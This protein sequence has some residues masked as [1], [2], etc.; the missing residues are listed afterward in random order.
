MGTRP[1]NTEAELL[2]KDR[3]ALENAENQSEIAA[4]LTE[5]GYDTTVIA[6]GKA[7]LAET[8]LAFD[9]NKTEDDETSEASATFKA[10]KK[11]LNDLFKVHR[12]KAKVI[13]RNDELTLK[14]LAINNS[15][16]NAYV[17]WLEEVK[18]FYTEMAADTEI[19]TKLARL[20]ITVEQITAGNTLV[21]E[22]ETARAEYL[23]EVG[24]SQ[25][26]TKIKDAAFLK[27]ANW[28]Q[29]FYAVA[30]IA[31]EDKPQLLEALGVVVKS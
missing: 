8:R 30:K 14:K 5:I 22:V 29:D 3:V 2:E 1:K 20:A 4:A 24:E 15:P 21:T 25:E 6:E 28:M 27:L 16:S 17:K 19:Q 13:F 11:E 18:K 31:L 10:K 9:T 26:A 23:R 7:I 12:K